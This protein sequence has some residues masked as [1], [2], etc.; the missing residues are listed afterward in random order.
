LAAKAVRDDENA[1][2]ARAGACCCRTPKAEALASK[3][4]M[5]AAPEN[6]IISILSCI[7]QLS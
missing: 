1:R 6:F 2:R 5:A 7:T 3:E 4:N